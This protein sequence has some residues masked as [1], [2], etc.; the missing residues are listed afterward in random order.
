MA[1]FPEFPGRIGPVLPAAWL[2]AA[3]PAQPV[4]GGPESTTS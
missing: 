2:G 4:S 3:G 1:L